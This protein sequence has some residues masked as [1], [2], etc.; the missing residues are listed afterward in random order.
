MVK[1]GWCVYMD[2][3]IDLHDKLL[4]NL[5]PE[6]LSDDSL[7]AVLFLILGFGVSVFLIRACKKVVCWW[8]GLIVFIEI[9]HFI[10]FRTPLGADYSILQTLFKYD[11]LSML[12]QCFVGTPIC[13]VLLYIR[14][15]LEGAITI[16]VICIYQFFVWLIDY[17]KNY[18]PFFS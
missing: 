9:M 7:R 13:H 2:V 14:A 15:F 4:K 5:N 17:L 16:A 11:V 8:V 1:R 18:T 6:I 12:A 10:A 3:V